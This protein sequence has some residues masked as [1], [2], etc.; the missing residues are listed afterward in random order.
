MLQLNPRY[1]SRALKMFKY[2]GGGHVYGH[3]GAAEQQQ[4]F[5]TARCA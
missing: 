2:H 5:P 1:Q 3:A 4:A